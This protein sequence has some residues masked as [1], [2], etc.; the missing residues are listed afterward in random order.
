MKLQHS[1]KQL[2]RRL[3]APRRGAWIETSVMVAVAVSSAFVA[4]RRGAWIET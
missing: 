3:V 1:V 2:F 4:P